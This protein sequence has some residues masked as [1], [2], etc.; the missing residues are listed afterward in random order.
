MIKI[1]SGI[2]YGL[3]AIVSLTA[4]ISIKIIPFKKLISLLTNVDKVEEVSLTI[5]QHN[6]LATI[7][8]IMQRVSY[9]VPWRVMCYEQAIIVL[10]FCRLLKINVN[11]SFG[12]RKSNDGKVLAHAWTR[13]GGLLVSGWRN[14][15]LFSNVYQRGLECAS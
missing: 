7:H 10:L 9:K 3:I 11:I 13:A 12:V 4:N 8:R 2:L 5:L 6:R 1:K 15:H 14:S